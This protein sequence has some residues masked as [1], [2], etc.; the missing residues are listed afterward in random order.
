MPNK[1]LGNPTG[2][3]KFNFMS[4]S[5]RNSQDV[6]QKYSAVNTLGI[7]D[8]LSLTS[9]DMTKRTSVNIALRAIQ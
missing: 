1:E 5:N 8:K 9:R 6:L 3:K 2:T 7:S 4:R